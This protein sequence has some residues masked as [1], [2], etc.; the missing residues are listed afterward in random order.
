M[1]SLFTLQTDKQR[2]TRSWTH[3]KYSSCSECHR[4][5]ASVGIS[6]DMWVGLPLLKDFF[7]ESLTIPPYLVTIKVQDLSCPHARYFD[8]YL[9]PLTGIKNALLDHFIQFSPFWTILYNSSPFWTILDG[10]HGHFE[11]KSKALTHSLHVC[12]QTLTRP[13]LLYTSLDSHGTCCGFSGSK[14]VKISLCIGNI[15]SSLW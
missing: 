15:H 2:S 11:I 1:V 9:P 14:L 4:H 5:G 3:H 12:S 8:G 7:R 6:V 10:L 13:L